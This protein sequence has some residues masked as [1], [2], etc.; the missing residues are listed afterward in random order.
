M[1]GKKQIQ[2]KQTNPYHH[3]DLRPTLIQAARDFLK[4]QDADSLSL[5]GIASAIGVTHMAPYA[6]FKGKQELL[7]AVAASGYDDLTNNMLKVQKLQS[8][9]RGRMLAYHYGVEYIL[10]AIANPNLYRLMMS[11]INLNQKTSF[12]NP[13]SEISL[14]SQRP[15][16]L[17]YTAFA[18][19]K[20]S[21]ELAHARAL[22]AWATVHGI[23][24]LAIEG[25]LLLPNG[26][27]IIQ[28]FKTTVSSTVDWG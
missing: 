7:E 25:H 14:S 22:G 11:Q 10:F 6:H 4:D 28:L 3:G 20:V 16:R 13:K 24:S 2:Q 27:D 12:E 9:V 8:K 17:L 5:R 18:T 23:S 19:E 1:A 21:K 26:M 15:F